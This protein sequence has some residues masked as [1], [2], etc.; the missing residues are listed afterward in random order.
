MVDIAA[1]MHWSSWVDLATAGANS[2]IPIVPGLYR[3]RRVGREDLDY[4]GQTGGALRGR[5]GMLKGAYVPEMPYRDPHTAGPGLWALRH[6]LG[7]EFQASV[8]PI[9]G[10]TPWRKGMEA[11]AIALYRQGRQAS[12]TLEF[13]RIPVGY[14]GSSGNNARLVAAGQRYRGGP[15][16]G[17]HTSH[18][19]GIPPVGSLDGDPVGRSWGGHAWTPW[20]PVASAGTVRTAVGLYR[21]RAAGAV[22]LI[23][24]GQGLIGSRIAAHM[25]KRTIAGHA[26]GGVFAAA[27]PLEASWVEAA[28]ES[29]QLLE[30]ENDLIAAHVLTV[31]NVP[32][33]QF[34]G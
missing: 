27:G 18:V 1:T 28:V 31:G 30:L 19:L 10:S 23:Y 13:G 34:L 2:T 22:D 3:I 26:Q 21:L 32:A 5:L 8:T 15:W 17:P 33:A 7:C 16:E 9:V 25:M 11:V 20:V 6:S 4:I 29:H 24:I 14:R 12:P